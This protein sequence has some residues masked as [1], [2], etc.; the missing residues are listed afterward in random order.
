VGS[1][2]CIDSKFRLLH[3]PDWTLQLVAR[4]TLT[5][6][7]IARLSQ[8]IGSLQ[9]FGT[10]TDTL[11]F[12]PE[13]GVLPRLKRVARRKAD[14]LASR[15]LER[16]RNPAAIMTRADELLMEWDGL[17]RTY[18]ALGDATSQEL[19]AELLV[20]RITGERYH[21]LSTNNSKYQQAL[22]RIPGMRIESDI[23]VQGDSRWVLDRFDLA[24]VGMASEV[25][26]HPLNL[27]NTFL[28]EQYRYDQGDVC[29]EVEPGDVVIDAGACW[30]DTSL[31]FAKLAGPDGV[32]I[33]V[34]F[35]PSNLTV[36]ELNRSLSHGLMDSVRVVDRPLWSDS[37]TVI[38][39]EDKGPS[40][41]FVNDERLP[42]VQTQTIDQLVAESSL[43]RVD[44]IK[45]D[46][47]GAEVPA[48]LGAKQ[49]IRTFRPKLAISAY[50]RPDDLVTI[51]RLFEKFGYISYLAHF[52]IH[53]E[54]TMLF[55]L[56]V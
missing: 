22:D 56:P 53:R 4:P 44:F 39:F 16:S 41:R 55:G 43:S 10:N 12:P 42:S 45:M 3:Q 38:H 40:T 35:V 46:I 31:Y 33:A 30:G 13:P 15:Y 5:P 48:L 11:R 52:T 1:S 51:P 18:E 26:C 50:H 8:G 49:T 17:E 6:E 14:S 9:A 7:F 37:E 36:L 27:V 47:E 25:L 29:I 32:V 23:V 24:D 21:R 34:E 54:E 20:F 19:L 2:G 28:L